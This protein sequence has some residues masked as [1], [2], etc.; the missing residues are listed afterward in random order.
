MEQPQVTTAAVMRF[1]IDLQDRST[2]FYAALAERWPE[3]HETFQA[4]AAEGEKNKTLILRTYQETISDALEASYSFEG[5]NPQDYV[6]DTALPAG[7]TLPQA[8]QT[9]IALEGAACAFY[10]QVAER[11]ESLLATIPG[12]FRRVVKTRAKRKARLEAM[13]K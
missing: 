7:A 1:T 10:T 4:F 2:A 5:L 9:A 11:S 3:H 12:A 13:L 6:V 8:V